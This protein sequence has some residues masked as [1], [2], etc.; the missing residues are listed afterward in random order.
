M[1]ISVL[2]Q[3]RA[4]IVGRA[5]VFDEGSNLRYTILLGQGRTDYDSCEQD[6]VL[7]RCYMLLG[8]LQ[9]SVGIFRKNKTIWS[10]ELFVGVNIY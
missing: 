1:E 7:A 8:S 9:H 6:S 10:K 4:C 2:S 5:N 3:V